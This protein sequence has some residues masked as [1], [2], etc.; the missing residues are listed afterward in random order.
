[1]DLITFKQS[2]SGEKTFFFFFK[3]MVLFCLLGQQQHPDRVCELL[4]DSGAPSSRHRNRRPAYGHQR[5]D[6]HLTSLPVT[7][8]QIRLCFTQ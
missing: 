2:Q 6:P 5:P 8:L 7:A 4:W 1:M 3:L